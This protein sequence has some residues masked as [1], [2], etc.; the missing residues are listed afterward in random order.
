MK[1]KDMTIEERRAY[2][3]ERYRARMDAIRICPIAF[4][5]YQDHW[6]DYQKSRKEAMTEEDR[7]VAK[8]KA[9]EYNKTYI[10]K[11]YADP[12]RLEIY[13]YKQRLKMREY[14]RRKRHGDKANTQT[15]L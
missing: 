11:L 1:I 9:R 8:E 5:R 10:K 15:D 14:Q 12:E 2:F 6:R 13:R 7:K 3:R 4:Q